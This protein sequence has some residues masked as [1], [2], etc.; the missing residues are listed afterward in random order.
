V[1]RIIRTL[2]TWLPRGGSGV[3]RLGRRFRLL[4]RVFNRVFVQGFGGRDA[5][6][7]DVVR[8]AAVHAAALVGPA[9][10]VAWVDSVDSM[11]STET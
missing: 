7:E 11:D 3:G 10:V 1:S 6:G 2:D 4:D 8:G 5:L 9:A